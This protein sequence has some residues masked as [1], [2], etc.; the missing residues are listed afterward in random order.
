MGD[1]K[2]GKPYGR[3]II[4]GTKTQLSSN[5]TPPDTMQLPL[6]SK[7]LLRKA[8]LL[9]K[10]LLPVMGTKS[11]SIYILFLNMHYFLAECGLNGSLGGGSFHVE[12][13]NCLYS[14]NTV[15][16][17]LIKPNSFGLTEL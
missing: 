11:F 12:A 6:L 10:H 13:L 4:E 5:G 14:F 2:K 9:L 3:L 15:T 1:L 17:L 8:N 7:V 16:A